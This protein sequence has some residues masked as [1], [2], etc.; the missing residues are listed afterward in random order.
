MRKIAKP[1][2]GAHICNG[3]DYYGFKASLGYRAVSSNI[4]TLKTVINKTQKNTLLFIGYIFNICI[5][6]PLKREKNY[7]IFT[8][9]S[10]YF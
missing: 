1:D 2:I 8:V 4:L 3:E 7:F 10:L 9:S 6:S 5:L